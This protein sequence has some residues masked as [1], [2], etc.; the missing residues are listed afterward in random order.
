[1][2]TIKIMPTNTLNIMPGKVKMIIH[3]PI[4]IKKYTEETLPELMQY[5]KV[6]I[7]SALPG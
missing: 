7:G 2:D 3:E 4:D 1:V 6:I 5:A